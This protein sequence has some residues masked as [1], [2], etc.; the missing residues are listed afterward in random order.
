MW[1]GLC[2]IVSMYCSPSGGRQP[3][4]FPGHKYCFVFF[5]VWRG[6][7]GKDYTEKTLS[8]PWQLN[9][10]VSI[11]MN[12]FLGV[13]SENGA[14]KYLETGGHKRSQLAYLETEQ[15]WVRMGEHRYHS[16][17]SRNS[18]R[19][20]LDEDRKGSLKN[21][22]D[23]SVGPRV[24]SQICPQSSITIKTRAGNGRCLNMLPFLL[25]LWPQSSF[26]FWDLMNNFY[27]V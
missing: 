6:R 2:D 1:S 24:W 25:P 4:W 5:A 18:G 20:I 22:D 17:Y 3:P 27:L 15:C 21:E 9:S 16:G 14:W 23:T 19:D 7:T 12:T 11:R 10:N 8:N 13:M 26:H